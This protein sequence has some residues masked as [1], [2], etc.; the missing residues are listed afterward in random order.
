MSRVCLKEDL[1]DRH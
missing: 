1:Q